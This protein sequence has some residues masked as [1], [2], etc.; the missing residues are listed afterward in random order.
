MLRAAR[1]GAR[2]RRPARQRA[3][4]GA[5]RRRRGRHCGPR[6]EHGQGVKKVHRRDHL[7][8]IDRVDGHNDLDLV[9]IPDPG[10][11]LR[12]RHLL[13]GACRPTRCLRSR[14]GSPRSRRSARNTGGSY[15]A[16]YLKGPFH[17]QVSYFSKNGKKEI[18][19]VII[20]DQSGR[21][22]E[23]WTGFQV[24][25]TMA[26]GYPGAFGRHVN[27]L[28]ISLPL[29]VL[30]PRCAISPWAA[31]PEKSSRGWR[32]GG[33]RRL[34]GPD[35][36]RSRARKNR[37]AHAEPQPLARPRAAIDTKP[38][39]EILADDVKCSHGA[40]VGDLDEAALFYLRARGIPSRGGAAH[41]DRGIFARGGR[42]R[43]AGVR[44][45]STCWRGSPAA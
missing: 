17:W 12:A 26:R 34:S 41:A 28:Y 2:R 43:R 7:A 1:P 44:C 31:R 16:Q 3:T 4:A 39:L 35:H 33:A 9:R 40:A 11:R 22:L 25:W 18:A 5:A 38:E 32:P 14:N 29:C 36:G 10:C 6:A 45:A 42:A 15:E 21:V 30:S 37:C 23:Q 27:A 13:A 19:Q 20:D 24:A 8:R